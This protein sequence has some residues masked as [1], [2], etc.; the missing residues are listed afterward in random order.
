MVD[1]E[2]TVTSESRGFS[3]IG[4]IIDLGIGGAA[5]ELD[6]PLRMGETVL[7]R[8]QGCTQ[9]TINATVMW[10]SWF[11]SSGVRIGLRFH[12]SDEDKLFAL[13]DVLG[14]QSDAGSE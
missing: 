2:A 7:L 11:E 6:V 8:F 1:L 14:V 10:V 12:D 3:A 13:L 9:P 4:R 5:C